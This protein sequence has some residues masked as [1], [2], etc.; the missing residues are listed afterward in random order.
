MKR[1]KGFGIVAIVLL[2]MIG[3]CGCTMNN[4]D[5]PSNSVSEI[6]LNERQKNILSEQGLPISVNELTDLQQKAIVAIEAMLQYAEEKYNRSFSYAGYTAASSLEKEHM[7]AYPSGG[8]K[9]TESF[10]I[11]KISTG[12][13]DDYISVAATNSFNAYIGECVTSLLN[14]SE[15]KVFSEITKASL[16]EVPTDYSSFDGNVESSIWIFIDG[17]SFDINQMAQ[18]KEDFSNTMKEHKLYCTAQLILLNEGKIAYP[19]K[20][21]YTDY[22]SEEYYLSRETVYVKK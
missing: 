11:T 16:N 7:R 13:E 17:A 21:N 9:Q 22:L 19:T 12:Y 15:V 3:A 6:T 4:S 18:F 20:Y 1:K 5:L 8:D 14:G 10:T 2:L